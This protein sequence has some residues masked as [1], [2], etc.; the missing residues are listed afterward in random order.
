VWCASLYDHLISLASSSF[1]DTA[2]SVTICQHL[3][4]Y[5]YIMGSIAFIAD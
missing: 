1:V 4:V 2:S 5:R 3:P